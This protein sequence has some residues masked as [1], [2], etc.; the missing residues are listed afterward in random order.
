MAFAHLRRCLHGPFKRPR[1]FR[2]VRIK[3]HHHED[4]QSRPELAAIKDSPIAFD[5]SGP[6]QFLDAAQTGGWRQADSRGEIGIAQPAIAL[7]LMQYSAINMIYFRQ[8]LLNLCFRHPI[9]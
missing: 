7:Q 3:P 2:Q 5:P 6:L 8:L 9:S 1:I 4:D